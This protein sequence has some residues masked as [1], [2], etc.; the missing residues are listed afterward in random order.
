MNVTDASPA[1]T[2]QRPAKHRILFYSHDTFGLG[3]FRRCLTIASYLSRHIPNLSVL[4]L[5]GLDVHGAFEAPAGVDFVKLPSIWK[6][7]ADRYQ[8]RHLRVSFARVRRMRK[9]LIRGVTRAFDPHVV[10]VDNVP[11]GAEGEM[12][13][14]LRHLR[15]HRPETRIV[16]TLRDVLDAPEKI[17]PKWRVQGVYD[18][19]RDFYDEI[20]VAGSR[21]VFDPVALYEIPEALVPRVKFCGYVVRSAQPEDVDLARR[22]L[23]M[24]E[25]PLVVAS[26]GGGGDGSQLMET[27]L[28]AAPGLAR[29]GIQSAVF[30]GPDMPLSLRRALKQR[31]GARGGEVLVFDFHPDLVSFLRLASASVSMAGYNTV[32]EIL[33]LGVPALVVPRVRPRREQVLRADAFAAHGLLE[34]LHPDSLTPESLQRAVREL[35]SRRQRPSL[36]AGTD[37]A[38][39]TRIARRV[40]KMLAHEPPR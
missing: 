14:T 10:V 24:K 32:C 37:F 25:G 6:A 30:L 31:A 1:A 15:G 28:E 7:D 17:V 16:L 11:R 21:S 27:Y 35:L 3:H 12:L 18:V 5:T 2:A 40:R 39:L 38:G 8:S 9:E 29:D 34:V 19:L 4:M 36:P 22:Q 20:W 26:C 23:S 13:P 33:S